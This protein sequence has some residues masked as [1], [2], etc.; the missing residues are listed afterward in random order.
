[1][2]APLR[3]SSGGMRGHEGFLLALLFLF[4][5]NHCELCRLRAS[6][7]WDNR[8]SLPLAVVGKMPS[9]TASFLRAVNGLWVIC[10]P[11]MCRGASCHHGTLPVPT[12]AT[13]LPGHSGFTVPSTPEGLKKIKAYMK[14]V[15]HC[16]ELC[17]DAR[18]VLKAHGAHR[19]F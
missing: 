7:A 12:S 17:W 13:S 11:K 16:M 14:P 6:P 1:M 9:R 18:A 4:P 19:Y 2:P 3:S 8:G 15:S 10:S 5:L